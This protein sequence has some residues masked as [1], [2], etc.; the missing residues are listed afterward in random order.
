MFR[1]GHKLGLKLI[2][3]SHFS[4]LFRRSTF[5]VE[6]TK[7]WRPVGARRAIKLSQ[8]KPAWAK[9]RATAGLI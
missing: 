7:F 5:D 1:L 3:Y 6:S 2:P 8:K 9:V 4:T